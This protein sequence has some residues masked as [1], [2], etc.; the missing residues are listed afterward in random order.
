MRLNFKVLIICS[1]KLYIRLEFFYW[2]FESEIKYIV[3]YLYYAGSLPLG[4]VVKLFEKDVLK[5]LKS[6]C[7]GLQTLLKNH[8]SIFHGI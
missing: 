1:L 5:Q 8:N 7:G 4:E 2:I 3:M 6:E